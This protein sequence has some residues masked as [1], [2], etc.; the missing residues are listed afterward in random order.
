M[1]TVFF[2]DSIARLGH[3]QTIYRTARVWVY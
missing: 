1:S 3:L 2:G